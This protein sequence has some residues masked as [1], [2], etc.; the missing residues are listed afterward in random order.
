MK[1]LALVALFVLV[2]AACLGSMARMGVFPETTRQEALAAAPETTI[3]LLW[4]HD[5]LNPSRVRV[6][7]G[8]RVHLFVETTA[9]T[10][11]GALTIPGYETLV[12]AILVEPGE[13]RGHVF[14]TTLPGDNFE[15]R[16]G[17]KVAGRLDVTGDHLGEDRL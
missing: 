4:C 14:E 16:V 9:E 3:V 15:I 8:T 10:S 5:A 12:P 6:P 13:R 7:T 11:P 1:R 2:S 17:G